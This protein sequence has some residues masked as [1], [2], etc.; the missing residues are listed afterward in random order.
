MSLNDISSISKTQN[1]NSKI[2]IPLL[3]SL[4]KNLDN[5]LSN[6]DSNSN[7]HIQFIND[8]IQWTENIISYCKNIEQQISHK[9]EQKK[10]SNSKP[11]NP[12]ENNNNNPKKM[13]KPKTPLRTLKNT[14]NFPRTLTESK[15]KLNSNTNLNMR[16]TMNTRKKTL[17]QNKSSTNV[18][19]KN[20]LNSNNS[21]NKN[22]VSN[23]LKNNN[24]NNNKTTKKSI[25]R[26]KSIILSHRPTLKNSKTL[27][28][29]KLPRK[30]INPLIKSQKRKVLSR[31]NTESNL[32]ISKGEKTLDNSFSRIISMEDT[33]PNDFNLNCDPI[34]TSPMNDLDFIP[35]GL[36]I[37]EDNLDKNY[38]IKTNIEEFIENDNINYIKYLDNKD[39]VNLLSTNKLFRKNFLKQIILNLKEEKN[40]FKEIISCFNVNEVGKK[41]N[42]KNIEMS[43]K[44][45]KAIQLLNDSCLNKLFTQKKPPSKDILLIY[46]LYFQMIKHPIINL[47]SNKNEFWKK[48]CEYFTKEE[49]GKTGNLLEKNFKSLFLD[50]E[51][52]YKLLQLLDGNLVKI[53][54]THF[55]KICRTTGLFT[56]YIKDILN[57][58]GITN[59]K[60]LSINSYWTYKDMIEVVKN[61]IEILKKYEASL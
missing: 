23:K 27:I 6:L 43:K 46:Y 30:S 57:Y 5:R 41:Y 59:E 28:N 37:N 32:N 18:I 33:F 14:M 13:I 15:L 1:L 55:S 61:K 39:K 22:N 42:I 45:E 50:P 51:N 10:E 7:S 19:Y 35:K 20:F 11:K 17:K 48:C 25:Q 4:L 3:T 8:T 38:V 53:N 34:L 54:L 31:I 16:K 2:E 24:N 58:L 21:L 29:L 26:R 47:K 60:T 52:I 56:F 44:T 36:L 12:T 9:K 49:G 40:K